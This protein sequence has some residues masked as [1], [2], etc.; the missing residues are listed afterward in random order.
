MI[1]KANEDGLMSQPVRP[2]E[3]RQSV[4]PDAIYAAINFSICNNFRG[5][6]SDFVRDDIVKALA[7]AD[8]NEISWIDERWEDVRA[9]YEDYG[10]SVQ[11]KGDDF[12]FYAAD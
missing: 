4:I 9:A 7:G 5:G 6:K 12:T 1:T 2:R 10:W 3:V 11:C 8:A